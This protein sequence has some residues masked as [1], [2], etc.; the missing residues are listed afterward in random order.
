MENYEKEIE[1]NGT[2]IKFKFVGT[3]K[4]QLPLLKENNVE[5]IINNVFTE[6]CIDEYSKNLGNFIFDIRTVFIDFEEKELNVELSKDNKVINFI[7]ISD[8]K[9]TKYYYQK[10]IDKKILKVNYSKEDGL[11]FDNYNHSLSTSKEVLLNVTKSIKKIEAINSIKSPLFSLSRDDKAIILI[12]ELFYKKTIDFSKKETSKEI[13]I[14]MA[15]LNKFDVGIKD[16]YYDVT[17]NKGTKEIDSSFD[18]MT[19]KLKFY[20]KI[21]KDDS[22]KLKEEKIEIIKIVAVELK[23]LIENKDYEQLTKL[24]ICFMRCDLKDDLDYIMGFGQAGTIY[25]R[26]EIEEPYQAMKKIGKLC[27]EYMYI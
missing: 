2:K 27:N 6:E 1:F 13:N 25:S 17:L 22:I 14:M 20:G 19:S 7:E 8:K 24:G 15:I 21:K 18:G 23:D 9:V 11:N 4:N 16:S 10:E 26:S 12:Y 3:P 5:D